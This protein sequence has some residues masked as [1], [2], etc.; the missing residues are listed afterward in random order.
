M[1]AMKKDHGVRD[2]RGLVWDG[3][4]RIERVGQDHY[5][6][7]DDADHGVLRCWVSETKAEELIA[8]GLKDARL[9]PPTLILVE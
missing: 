6:V 5:V 2:A 1:R 3:E 9:D 8:L 4:A 7:L